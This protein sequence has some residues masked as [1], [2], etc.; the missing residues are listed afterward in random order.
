MH[1]KR[2]FRIF[3]SCAVAQ[4]TNGNESLSHGPINQRPLVIDPFAIVHD[5]GDDAR[6]NLFGVLLNIG[7]LLGV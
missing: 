1:S 3:V 4:L 5:H 2:E 6:T 7:S